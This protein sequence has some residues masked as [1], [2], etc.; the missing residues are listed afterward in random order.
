MDKFELS[1]KKVFICDLILINIMVFSVNLHIKTVLRD[2]FEFSRFSHEPVVE[3][4]RYIQQRNQF[5]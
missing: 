1:R 2:E 4:L 3:L 5:Y